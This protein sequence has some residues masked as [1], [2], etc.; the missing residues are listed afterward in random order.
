VRLGLALLAVR[1]AFPTLDTLRGFRLAEFPLRSFAR[2]CSFDAF[3]RL[4]MSV[5][6]LWFVIHNAL[7]PDQKVIRES[8]KLR[9]VCGL[10]GNLHRDFCEMWESN[11]PRFRR[12]GHELRW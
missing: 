2:F 12:G 9:P 7:M 1:S 4:A 11:A 5:T 3:L 8:L 10:S 6:L